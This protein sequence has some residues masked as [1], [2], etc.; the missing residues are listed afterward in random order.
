MV[1]P[2]ANDLATARFLRTLST[3]ALELAGELEST[4]VTDKSSRINLRDAGL[5]K[6]QLAVAN[7]VAT[8]D[9]SH[10]ISPREVAKAM[11]RGDEPNVRTALNRLAER[12]VAERLP[13][14]PTQRWRLAMPYRPES[15]E[16][17]DVR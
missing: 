3:A 6:L 7:A 5:G 8:A 16:A 4:V 12:G 15:V 17:K 13:D 1:I 14:L 10:G 2:T 11:H 9:P